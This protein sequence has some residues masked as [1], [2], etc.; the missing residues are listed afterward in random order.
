M[1]SL[2]SIIVLVLTLGLQVDSKTVGRRAADEFAGARFSEFAARFN[3]KMRAAA[4]EPVLRQ[5]HDRLTQQL[6]AY[7][8][9][10]GD[11]ACTAA[12]GITSCVTPL[13]FERGRLTLRIALSSDGLVAGFSIVGVEPSEGLA[14]GANASIA[15]GSLTLP[16]IITLPKAG[17]P[18]PLIVLVHG[19]GAHDADETVGPNKPFRDLAE[20]L[21]ARGIATLRYVKRNRIAPLT[22]SATLDD[23]V[24]NDALAAVALARTTPGVDASRIFVLG[25]SLGGYMAPHIASKDPQIRG[26]VVMAGN[27]RTSRESL[28]DQLRHLTG[29]TD[30]LEAVMQQAPRRYRELLSG[31]DPPVAARMLMRPVLVLQGGRDYQVNDKDYERWTT[32]LANNPNA[33][34]KLYPQLNHLFLEGEGKSLPAEYDRPGRIPSQVLDDIAAWVLK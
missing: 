17:G 2:L 23:E 30:G 5:A 20:G 11:T 29:T 4:S 32:T 3:E 22:A 8:T 28:S 27:T 14:P 19:S 26:I 6:G 10:A 34:F 12:A 15:V 18:A 7:K 21:A 33:T 9:I 25:H 31:Y 13:Q 1:T 16:A 24:T